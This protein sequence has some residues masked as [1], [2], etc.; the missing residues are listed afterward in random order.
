VADSRNNRIL[1]FDSSGALI[2]AWGKSSGNDA[3][4]PN[5]AAAPSTFNEPWG[6]AVG[7]D[8]SVYVTDTWNNRIQKFTANGQFIKMWTT[9]QA[10]QADV[11]YGPR[12]LA[13][14]AKGRVYVADTGN[15]RIVVFDAD[16]NFLTQ[17]GSDGMEAG[18]FD[19]PVGVTV[20][21]SG[22][23][24]V[25]DTWNQRV[26]TFSPSPDG[27]NFSPLKQWD[28][29]A[30]YGQ[31]L[32]N[33]P[34]IAVDNKGHVFI[35]DPEGFRVIEY[36]TDGSLVQTWGDYGSTPSTFGLAAGITIDAQGNIWVSDAANNR[37]MRFTLP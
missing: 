34:F 7:P 22:N 33:K 21:A 5:P 19:E 17:F 32:D 2:N 18:Q 12:G 8:G 29:A 13:V 24:Y 36:S 37:L 27:M 20:D 16:G 23:V 11:F 30:W 4:H 3:S 35:T 1:H 10:G 26:Q 31:S 14:D 28:V 15:K 9:G 25:T 6:V